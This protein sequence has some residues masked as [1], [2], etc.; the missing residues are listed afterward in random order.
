MITVVPV[1]SNTRRVYPFQ[2]LLE[3]SATALPVVTTD[4]GDNAAIVEDGVTGFVVRPR[5]PGALAGA[6]ERMLRLGP[7]ER[8]AMGREGR[9]RVQERY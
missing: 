6:M 9:A 7:F 5:D 4:V 1:T 3:A 2:V 8:D